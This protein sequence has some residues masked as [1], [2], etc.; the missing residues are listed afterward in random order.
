MKRAYLN[1]VFRIF[2]LIRP[3]LTIAIIRN[4]LFKSEAVVRTPDKG[5]KKFLNC[6]LIFFF[7]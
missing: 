6:G 3:G 4:G 5:G 2:F 1:F 7:K